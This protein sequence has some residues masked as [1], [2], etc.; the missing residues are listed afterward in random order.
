MTR[1][2]SKRA[3]IL[4]WIVQGTLAVLFLFAGGMKQLM[5]AAVL[6]QQSGLPGWF[7]RS[8]GIAEIAGGLGLVLPGIFRIKRGLTPLAGV[9]LLLVMVGATVISF[10]RLSTAAA[11][12]PIA[13]GLLL[14]AVIGGRRH[15]G[16]TGPSRRRTATGFPVPG[17]GATFTDPKR[18]VDRARA[19]STYR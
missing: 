1:T 8:I 15:W 11:M 13:V 10:L 17:S 2:I 12:L 19:R 18:P 7:M 14:T 16:T 6:A 3:N 5:P 9:G 4:L